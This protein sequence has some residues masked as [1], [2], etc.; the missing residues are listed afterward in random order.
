MYIDNNKKFFRIRRSLKIRCKFKN[1]NAMRLVVH[2]TSRHIYAQIINTK[3]ATVLT[4]ASTLEKNIQSK[5]SSYTGNKLSAS[6]IGLMIAQRALKKG[7]DS[8]IFDRSGFKY[9]GRIKSLAESARKSG[10]K[11]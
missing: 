11:F 1:L 8:V 9:H 7:V 6:F 10:L 2:R 4:T 5:L 3:T